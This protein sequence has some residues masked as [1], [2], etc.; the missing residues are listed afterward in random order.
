VVAY[1]ADD[2]VHELIGHGIASLML[3]VKMLSISTVGLQIA[4]SSRL[5]GAAGA[6]RR[7]SLG[8]R[9][10]PGRVGA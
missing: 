8:F 2:T 9:L 3:N 5:V 10:L 4:E 7:K 6:K 1:A